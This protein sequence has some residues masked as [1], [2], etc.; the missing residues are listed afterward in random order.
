MAVMRIRAPESEVGAAYYR[1]GRREQRLVCDCIARE[2]CRDASLAQNERTIGQRARFFNFR[3]SEEDADSLG[4]QPAK[5]GID[6]GFRSHIHSARRFIQ[7]QQ[8]RRTHQA[9]RD[10]HLLL[11]AA[12]E[13]G[14]RQFKIS[15]DDVELLR[16]LPVPEPVARAL[17][18][19]SPC[20][21]PMAMFSRID[22]SGIRPSR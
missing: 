19:Q 7:K 21:E 8:R 22:S 1:A 9:A 14:Y 17:E 16:E 20:M 6:L 10:Q 13:R 15:G 3:R 2:I 12:G 4:R 5:D 18:S 11:I